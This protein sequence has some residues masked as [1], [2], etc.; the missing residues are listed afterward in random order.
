MQADVLDYSPV[1]AF[2]SKIEK[3]IQD[4]LRLLKFRVI[5]RDQVSDITHMDET[6]N[7]FLP[8]K[9]ILSFPP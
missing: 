1:V 9:T 6:V 4:A 2:K 5:I 7:P 8:R 3:E